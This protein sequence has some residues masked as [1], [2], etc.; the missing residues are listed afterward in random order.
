MPRRALLARAAV[1]AATLALAAAVALATAIG[2][3]ADAPPASGPATA[4]G[5]GGAAATVDRLATSAAIEALRHGGNA[6]DAAVT[7]AAVLGVTEPFSC[8]IGGGGF[9]VAYDARERRVTTIDHRETAPGAMRPDSF[10][11][12]GAPLPFDAARYSGLSVGVPGTVD[13]WADALRRHGTISLA[14]ALAPAIR[15]AQDGFVV[16]DTFAAQTQENRDFFDDAPA[17]AALFL[18]PDG[19]PHD[20]GTVFRNPD[21]ARTLTRIAQRGP[22]GFYDGDVANAIV[23][24]VRRPPVS[25]TANHT[26]RPGVMAP[27]D[28]RTY[29]AIERPPTHVGY[30][31]LDVFGMGPPSSGGSTVGEALNILE[32]YDLGSLPREQAMHLRFEASRLAFADRGAY[33][34]D[35]AYFDVPLRGLLSDDFAATRRALIGDRAASSPVAPGDPYPFDGPGGARGR[36]EPSVTS[37]RAGSTTHI[38]VSDRWG[39]VVSYTFTI[40]STGGSGLVVPGYG[41]LLNNEL[42]DFNYDS[43]THPNR[44]EPGKRPRSSMSPTIVLRDGAPALTVG[45]PGGSMIITTVLQLLTDRL[46]LGMTLPQ[47]IAAPRASQRNTPTT[48]AEPAFLALPEVPA[49]Q[50]RGQVFTTSPEIGA[51]TGIEFGPDG[52]LLAAAEPVRR[53]GGSAMVVRPAP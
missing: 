3:S 27:R 14:Q 4:T 17:T 48:A 22:Q 52:A 12:A 11:N 15:I 40:E 31:G 2:A 32:G 30:R 19:T 36:G 7:A 8:G 33:V 13:G 10:F 53:G 29:R 23:D 44:V 38:S 26:W 25:A 6:V 37:Q 42:T 43:L 34:A 39:D 49:L 45:S 28:L 51:A 20:V 46:D 24:A 16:D 18:D 47:A 1:L 5:S 21:L 41:F 35:P 50:A 9:M